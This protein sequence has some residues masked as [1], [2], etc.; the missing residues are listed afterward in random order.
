MALASVAPI[1]IERPCTTTS[2]PVGFALPNSSE[3]REPCGG[4]LPKFSSSLKM[5]ESSSCHTFGAR[6]S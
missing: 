6:R 5:R 4:V 1:D 3:T 2:G